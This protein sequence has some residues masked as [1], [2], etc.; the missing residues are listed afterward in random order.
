MGAKLGLKLWLRYFGLSN[1]KDSFP[2]AEMGHAGS[3][4]NFYGKIKSLALNILI[5]RHLLDIQVEM[6]RRQLDWDL[7]FRGDTRSG[8]M[9]LEVI[10]IL[11]V[12]KTMRLDELTWGMSIDRKEKRNKSSWIVKHR[13]IYFVLVQLGFWIYLVNTVFF[14]I[15]LDIFYFVNV[16]MFPYS[17]CWKHHCVPCPCH[18]QL[19]TARSINFLTCSQSSPSFQTIPYWKHEE[20]QKYPDLP[21][22]GLGLSC[23]PCWLGI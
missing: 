18:S 5:L 16:G 20:F 8:V 12:I 4:I 9:S 23:C 10:S 1:W 2:S 19:L 22:W 11:M 6:S 17:F 21:Q 7:G 14:S 3:G 15:Q 13:L